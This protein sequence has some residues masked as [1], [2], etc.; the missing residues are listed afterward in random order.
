MQTTKTQNQKLE[1]FLRGTKRTLTAA[2]AQARF[3][4]QNLSARVAELRSVGLD[5]RTGISP[6]TGLA[7]YSMPVRNMWG[8]KARAFA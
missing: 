1:T 2:Q 8:S 7:Q 5:V 4:I 3:G 6:S